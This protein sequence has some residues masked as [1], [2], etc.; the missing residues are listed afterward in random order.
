MKKQ[1][2]YVNLQGKTKEERAELWEFLDNAGEKQYDDKKNFINDNY[3]NI[4]S[5]DEDNEW[6]LCLET[7]IMLEDKK[8]VTIDQLKQIIKPMGTLEQKL[9]KEAT[10]RGF[11]NGVKFYGSQGAESTKPMLINDNIKFTNSYNCGL[12]VN[13]S[14]I[15]FNGKWGT[16]IEET[17]QQQLQKAEAEVKRLKEEIKYKVGNKVE[18]TITEENRKQIIELMK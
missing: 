13:N 12:Y 10:E 4:L 5:L 9:R 15:C 3:Y 16:L 14:W 8:E 18:V 1:E 2:I 11:V 6:S 7:S 17:L